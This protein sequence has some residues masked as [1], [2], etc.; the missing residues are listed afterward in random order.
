M[1]E[2]WAVLGDEEAGSWEFFAA[3]RKPDAVD[4]FGERV[5][6]GCGD[7]K[8]HD[9]ERAPWHQGTPKV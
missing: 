6:G 4:G 1:A 5:Q 2:A 7:L 8:K 3:R 9:A